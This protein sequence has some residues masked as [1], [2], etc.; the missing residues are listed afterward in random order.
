MTSD[1]FTGFTT[2]DSVAR[3]GGE[4]ITA[5]AFQ[6]AYTTMVQQASAQFGRQLTPDQAR[7]ARRAC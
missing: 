5:A 2:D 1:V 4:K 6:Q 3:V 7:I